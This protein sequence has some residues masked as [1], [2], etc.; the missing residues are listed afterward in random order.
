MTFFGIKTPQPVEQDRGIFR[1]SGLV[2]HGSQTGSNF[3]TPGAGS[4]LFLKG[5]TASTD[6]ATNFGLNFSGGTNTF[7]GEYFMPNSGL[8]MFNYVGMEPSGATN[9]PLMIN[10]FNAGSVRITAF[11]NDSL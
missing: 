2:F 1:T 7:I 11:G 6:L 3:I 8:E 9:Q 4:K 5:F 10:L